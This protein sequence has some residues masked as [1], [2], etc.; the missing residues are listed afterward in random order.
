MLEAGFFSK[1][2]ERILPKH[3]LLKL[4]DLKSVK[5][6]LKHSEFIGLKHGNVLYQEGDSTNQRSYIVLNGKLNLKVNENKSK[7]GSVQTGDSLGEE[8]LFE[9]ED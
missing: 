7:V 3:K 8:G 9:E 5:Q 4:L 2:I 6:L 1:H